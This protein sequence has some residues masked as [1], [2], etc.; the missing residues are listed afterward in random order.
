MLNFT[1]QHITPTSFSLTRKTKQMF[2]FCFYLLFLLH[3]RLTVWFNKAVKRLNCDSSHCN[4]ITKFRYV[5]K[6][7]LITGWKN[8]W[9]DVLYDYNNVLLCN[10]S[11]PTQHI[12][13]HDASL[14]IY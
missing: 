7:F 4:V 11:L 12:C 8:G 10:I 3:R 14:I 2:F 13:Q 1:Y 5:T 9:M 6:T